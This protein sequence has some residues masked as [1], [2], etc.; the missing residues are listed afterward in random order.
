MIHLE[1]KGYETLAFNY[2]FGKYEV[3]LIMRDG[4][5]V[6]AVEVK[7][8]STPDYGLPQDFLKRG[9]IKR[10]VQATDHFMQNE[11]PHDHEVRFDFVGIIQNK[12]GTSYEHLE[13]AF[14]HF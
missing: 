6:V 9:Q 5:T 13:D 11:Y 10:I 14:F 1:Q 7:G 12:A 3:D 8:R 2:T 4:D